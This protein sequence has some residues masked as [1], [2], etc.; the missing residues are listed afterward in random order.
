MTTS[1][2]I[3]IAALKQILAKIDPGSRPEVLLAEDTKFGIVDQFL[4]EKAKPDKNGIYSNISL[5]K[6]SFPSIK[7]II[8]KFRDSPFLFERSQIIAY[9]PIND[10]Y[11]FILVRK[12][13][14][15]KENLDKYLLLL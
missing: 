11:H 8:E 13:N 6:Q 4:F 9:K 1:R 7:D 12:L 10:N 14:L 15:N 5:V 3:A 2:Q